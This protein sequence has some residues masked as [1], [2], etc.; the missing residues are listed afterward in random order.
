[1][2][3]II[4]VGMLAFCCYGQYYWPVTDVFTRECNSTFGEYRYNTNPIYRHFHEG[5]DIYP[6]SS[7]NTVIST[8]WG[9][10]EVEKI[11][12]LGGTFGY[13]VTIQHY[14]FTVEGSETTWVEQNYGSRYLHMNTD[15]R[16]HLSENHRYPDDVYIIENS[17]FYNNHLHFEIRSPA[18]VGSDY[19]DALNPMFVDA[20]LCPG[21]D[22]KPLLLALY[23]DGST[24]Q[25]NHHQ[26]DAVINSW[27]FLKYNF[28][29]NFYDSTSAAPFVR[30]TLPTETRDNDLDDPH[31]LISG[32]RKVRFVL[33]AKDRVSSGYSENCAPY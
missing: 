28:T 2:R 6:V 19:Q 10:Y 20:N 33:K 14:N 18:P 11:I 29:T 22:N 4:L 25:S 5:I 15:P 7:G 30:L 3:Y 1:M 13:A 26:G 8:W 24:E 16:L 9:G 23:A 12:F 21:D 27:N 32:N 31:I 17:Y